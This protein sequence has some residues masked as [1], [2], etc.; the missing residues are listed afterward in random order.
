MFSYFFL[1]AGFAPV[2]VLAIKCCMDVFYLLVRLIFMKIKIDFS[3]S[4]FVL[5]TILP[6]FFVSATSVSCV[7][8]V[9][10]FA[11]S[12]VARLFAT[13]GMFVVVY[14]ILVLFAALNRNDRSK[15]LSF[16]YGKIRKV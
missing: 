12:D 7:Y 16:F 14:I 13:T 5:K 2:A 15:I 9:S 11:L 8:V 1:R 10:K 6:V 3:I 4:A